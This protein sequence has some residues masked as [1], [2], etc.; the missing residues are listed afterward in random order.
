M[1]ES[2][3]RKKIDGI[4]VWQRGGE[5][6]PHKSLLLLYA[7]ARLSRDSSNL[8][9]YTEIDKKLKNL[10]QEFGPTRKTNRTQYPFLRLRNDELWQVRWKSGQEEPPTGNVDLSARELRKHKAAGG[11]LD[12]IHEFLVSRPRVVGRL[13]GDILERNFPESI[14]DDILAGIEAQQIVEVVRRRV[15][16][17]KFRHNILTAYE[18]QCAICGFDVRV[19]NLPVAIEAAHIKWRQVNG[20][21]NET[22]G[23]A[24]CV[25][26]HR[27]FDRGAFTIG[28][29]LKF[30]VSEDV[31]GGFGVDEWLERYH[32]QPMRMPSR[33][34][35]QPA[36]EF[37][38]WHHTEVF[39]GTKL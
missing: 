17:P 7:L 15:R 26:H 24:L 23:I 34:E 25:M 32:G 33:V 11:F 27:L 21:D 9:P 5:R 19:R 28:N 12:E 13:I 29:D 37:I 6:A 38:G 10:L 31:S 20:P 3:I 8:I 39:R 2:E 35:Y 18:H 30:M 4:K 22:N 16:D 36:E 1:N 14:H